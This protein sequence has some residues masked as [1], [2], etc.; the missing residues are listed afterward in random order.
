MRNAS[1]L[2]AVLFCMV[3]CCFL[4]PSNAEAQ[5]VLADSVSFTTLLPAGE[6]CHIFIPA[7]TN[8]VEVT[9]PSDGLTPDA[10]TAVEIAPRWLQ[11]DL[12]DN[13]RRLEEDDQ[14]LYAGM[15]INAVPPY[16][17]EICFEVAHTAPRTLT[18]Y[19]NEQVLIDNVESLYASDAFLDYADIIDYDIG[20]DYYS[21]IRYW[22]F[23]DE[24]IHEFE[25]PRDIYYW[26]VVHPKLHKETPNYINPSTGSPADPPTGV[27]WRDYLMNHNDAGYPL[28]RDCLE[29]CTVLWR[30]EQNTVDNGAV[31]AVTQWIQDVMTFQS[32]PHHD[33]PVR[34]YHR[35]IGTCS[36]HSYLTSATARAALIPAAVDVMYS[37]NHKINEFWDRRWIAWEPVNTFIDNP[38]AYENWGWDVAGTFNW[39]GD[40][41]IWETTQRYTEVCTLNVNVTD[42]NGQPVDGARIKIR[43]NPCVSWGTTAGWTDYN[44]DKQFL[45]GDLRTFQ[46]R[47]TSSIGNY[48]P[49]IMETIIVNSQP[50]VTYS[51]DVTLAGT[52]PTIDVS[53]DTLPANPTNNYRLVIDYDLPVEIL[54]GDNFDDYNTFS[55]ACAGGHI[56]F[57]VC[58]QENFTSYMGDEAF[59]A[60]EISQNSSGGSVEHV[61][62]SSDPWYA[63]F[64]NKTKVVLTQELQCTVRLYVNVSSAPEENE[65]GLSARARLYPSYPDPFDAE[66]QIRFDIAHGG[67]TELA[68][69]NISGQRVRTLISGFCSA[70]EHTAIWDGGDDSGNGVTC[71]IYFCKLATSDRS[72]VRRIVRIR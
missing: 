68:I 67:E 36:V 29:P 1:E 25:L 48:P 17:D 22:V 58:S 23:E 35:H 2:G 62:V 56:D 72:E 12:R 55:E 70:G 11:R 4:A 16:V 26:Y 61:L 63:V 33:Q 46:A 60:F 5:W 19:M 13:F 24:E 57:F 40:S 66:T 10:V 14:N 31:G 8:Y 27:F 7:W 32:S 43:S 42:I 28:L 30:S 69:Y 65:G 47:V 71:G 54:Y 41:F 37:D 15:I 9:L 20:E 64:C 49:S 44:G 52:V 51:W 39:R 53:P 59:Q 50:G 6:D 21:T 18:S 34:I 3:L 45:L 38:Q